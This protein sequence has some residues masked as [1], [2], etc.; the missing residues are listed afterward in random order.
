MEQVLKMSGLGQKYSRS[1]Q[2]FA[3]SVT[4]SVCDFEWNKPVFYV[5][6]S[7]KHRKQQKCCAIFVLN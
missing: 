6:H 2:S 3:S 4:G 1:F 5:F 7:T